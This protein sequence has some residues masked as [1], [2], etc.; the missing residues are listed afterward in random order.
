MS[1]MVPPPPPQQT[2][3]RPPPTSIKSPVKLPARPNP[4]PVMAR[5][6]PPATVRE[7]KGPAVN[8]DDLLKSV[9][10]GVETKKVTMAPSA[11]KKGGSTGK[12]SVTIKL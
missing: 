9:N 10:S 7:M 2:S 1:G 3:V 4:Q 6:D 5:V 11:T 12:N 8:I